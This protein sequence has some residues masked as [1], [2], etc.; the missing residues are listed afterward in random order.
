MR[1]FNDLSRQLVEKEEIDITRTNSAI[2]KQIDEVLK[3]EEIRGKL[4]NNQCN[5]F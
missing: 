3:N 2:D 1:K 5:L 4:V